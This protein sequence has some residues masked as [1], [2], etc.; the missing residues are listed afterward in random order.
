MEHHFIDTAFVPWQG[1]QHLPSFCRTAIKQ[2]LLNL[3]AAYRLVILVQ[4][5]HVG[6]QACMPNPTVPAG[7]QQVYGTY[8]MALLT[9]RLAS[10]AT[11]RLDGWEQYR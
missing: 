6:Q 10:V 9:Y 5:Q 2:T 4:L 11:I 3:L 7:S 8:K 1:I